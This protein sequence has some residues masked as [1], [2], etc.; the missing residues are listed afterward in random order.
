MLNIQTIFL[1]KTAFISLIYKYDIIIK[2]Q[3]KG[4][5]LMKYEILLFDADETLFDFK[6]SE[7]EALKNAMRELG[8]DYDENYHL[9]IYHDI[10]TAIWK[11]FED[12]RITQDKLQVER[13][14]RFSD[15]INIKFDEV[16]FA[17]AYMNHLSKSSFLF[18]ESETLIKRLHKNYR[19]AM[20]TNG[21]NYV[22]DNRIKKSSIAKYFE[23][24]I[25]S[26]EIKVSKPN[27]EIFEIAL[28]QL[29]F[30]DKDRII[31]IGDSLSSDIKG[32]INFGIDTCWYNPNN[33]VNN[34]KFKPTY[35]IS[36]LMDILDILK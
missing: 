16:A 2:T 4:G 11:E 21:L 1:L 10:N 30:T 27:P 18:Q 35:E 34:T 31:M 13:F 5:K 6:K 9:K 25:V 29:N 23:I 3:F 24:I 19:L 12:G 7:K 20:I 32:G 26:E 14:K 28:N 22:Q 36:N 17:K 33:S 15:K 8:L